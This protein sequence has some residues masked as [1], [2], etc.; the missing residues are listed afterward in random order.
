MHFLRNNKLKPLT[1][2][3]IIWECYFRIFQKKSVIYLIII[4][5]FYNKCGNMFFQSHISENKKITR[6]TIN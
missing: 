4:L 5:L 1:S 3:N 2:E 6:K